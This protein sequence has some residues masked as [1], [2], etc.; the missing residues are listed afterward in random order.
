M[1]GLA[2]LTALLLNADGGTAAA[3]SDAELLQWAETAFSAGVKL[4]QTKPAHAVRSFREAAADYEE[5]R[6]RGADNPD[7]YRNAGNAW[8]LAGDLPRAI[9]AYRRGLRLAPNDTALRDHLAAAREEVVYPPPGG[10]GRPPVDQHPPWL[11]RLSPAVFLAA[12]LGLYVLGWLAMTRWAMT[13]R[14]WLLTT[15]IATFVAALVLG[16]GWAWLAL[17]E[18]EETQQPLVVINSDGVLLRSGNGLSYPALYKTPVN[19]GVEAR[20][21]V[22]RGDWLKIRLADGESGWVPGEYALV[23]S[24]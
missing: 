5:L 9:L 16:A 24:D 21:L 3:L 6:R 2:L 14:G 20:L 22:R 12:A 19:R 18:Q 4:R 13:H 11:P 17:E 10:F 1:V 23:D 15:G 8:L 7:L